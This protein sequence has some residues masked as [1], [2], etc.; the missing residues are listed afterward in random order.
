MDKELPKKVTLIHLE[1]LVKD[2]LYIYSDTLTICVITLLNGT[3]ITGES[4]CVSHELYN[5]ALGEQYAKQQAVEKIWPLE[6]Y[7][8]KQR[9][10]E[11]EGTPK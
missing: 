3:K 2:T 5:R 4:A 10:Y 8:L 11:Q 6:G 7:L 1:S 9:M